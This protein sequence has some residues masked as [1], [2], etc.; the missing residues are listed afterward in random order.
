MARRV[1]SVTAMPRCSRHAL[2]LEHLGRVVV[3]AVRE[4]GEQRVAEVDDVDLRGRDRE[5]VVLDASSSRGRGPRARRRAPRRSARRRRRRSSARPGRSA[6]GRGRPSS[7][8]PRMRE[9]SRD[10]VVE[11]VERE[12]VLLARPACGR[13]SAAIRPPARARRPSTRCP[14]VVVDRAGRPGR[15]TSTSASLTSTFGSLA[16]QLAQRVRDVA[17]RE[18]RGRHLVEQ[19]LEL[20]VVV[21][22]DQRDA[23]VVVLGQPRAQPTPAKP[24][25]T[26]T[27]CSRV[28]TDMGRLLPVR[29]GS[30]CARGGGRRRAA[31]SPSR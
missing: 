5:V 8:T 9:R 7:N 31:R 18:L 22:V 25:P 28:V 24:P 1:I 12:R 3:R 2:A 14:S 4:R 19:R 13:S 21:A 23:H 16:E 17:R 26:T 29:A 30:P 11:R 6:R 27:T 20:V 15:P 10:R